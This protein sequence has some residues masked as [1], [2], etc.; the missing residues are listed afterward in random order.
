MADLF[1]DHFNSIPDKDGG[2]GKAF[3]TDS[4]KS[5]ERPLKRQCLDK[6]GSEAKAGAYFFEGMFM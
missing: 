6:P 4:M 5:E 1:G 2:E 3:K